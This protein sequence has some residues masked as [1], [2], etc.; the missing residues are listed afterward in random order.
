M[1]KKKSATTYFFITL[2]VFFVLYLFI[3]FLFS[4]INL[5]FSDSL[6]YVL[7]PKNLLT[8]FIASVIYASIM[9]FLIKKKQKEINK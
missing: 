4:L 2:I 8:K 6:E 3:Q 1:T 9:A 7:R 5:S